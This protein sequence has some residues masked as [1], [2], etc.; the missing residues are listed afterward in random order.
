MGRKGEFE[1]FIAHGGYILLELRVGS[2]FY[3]IE[4]EEKVRRTSA[5]FFTA[6]HSVPCRLMVMY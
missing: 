3:T 1:L 4:R 6:F 5:I 2:A